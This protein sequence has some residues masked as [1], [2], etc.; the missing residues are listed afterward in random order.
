MRKRKWLTAMGYTGLLMLLM[1]FASGCSSANNSDSGNSAK[2]VAN[3]PMNA[4]AGS[5]AESPAAMEGAADQTAATQSASTDAGSGGGE[6]SAGGQAGSSLGAIADS[7]G[8]NRKIVYRGNVSMEVEDYKAAQQSVTGAIANSGGYI[9]QFTDQ[10]TSSELG[11]TYTIK[12]P[13]N[14]FMSFLAGI[15]KLPHLAFEK[16]MEGTDVT[17]EYVDLESRLKARGVVEARLLAFMEKAESATALLQFSKELGEVQ[18]EIE[19]IKGRMRYLDQNVAYSTIELRIYQKSAEPIRTLSEE[20]KFGA[21]I[22]GAWSGSLSF[23]AEAAQVIVIVLTA[24][25]PV[26]VVL[27]IIAVPAY[28]VY[29]RK[30]KHAIREPREEGIPA[31][32]GLPAEQMESPQSVADQER[33][34]VDE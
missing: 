22:A 29:R 20:K 4:A 10:Q 15:E 21:R 31:S 3:A 19:R 24:I 7:D 8:F 1:A 2:A 11:G 32:V 9:L 14:G 27:G 28:A 12:V 6:A 17:E 34:R 18:T 23:L 25:L 5:E 16:S 13:A 33:D 26:A 30:R